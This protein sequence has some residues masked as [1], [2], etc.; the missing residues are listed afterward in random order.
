[1][2]IR[3][4]TNNNRVVAPCYNKPIQ[5]EEREFTDLNGVFAIAEYNGEI[6]K[7]DYLEVFNV[8]VKTDTWT[9]PKT[10]Q[11]EVKKIV[12][13]VVKRSEPVFDEN[14]EIIDYK[15]FEE[16]IEEEITEIVQETIEEE[17]SRTYLTC[18]LVANFIQLTEEQIAEQ[19][20]KRYESLCQQYI[21][22]RYSPT[23]ENKVVREYLAD[24]YNLDKKAQFDEYNTYVESC[25]IKAKAEV[26][27]GGK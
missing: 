9:E 27:G 21:R 1:M 25:K 11:K 17:K 10:I 15:V 24:M 18:D 16:T 5:V 3:F 12:P 20:Q 2:Y 6:P 4:R 22:E 23:D 26:Y 19:K 14:K 13:K 8:Q 7:G